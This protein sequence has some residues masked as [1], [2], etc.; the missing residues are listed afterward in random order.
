MHMFPPVNFEYRYSPVQT[1]TMILLFNVITMLYLILN[2][3][4]HLFSFSILLSLR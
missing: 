1:I 3:Y 2:K 4:Y